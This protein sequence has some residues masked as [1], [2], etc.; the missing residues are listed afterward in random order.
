MAAAHSPQGSAPKGRNEKEE[1]MTENRT[2]E[3]VS[4]YAQALL[5]WIQ[6]YYPRIVACCEARE[7]PRPP[8]W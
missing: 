1:A 6:E 5:D 2:L 3:D 4:A 7:V 8:H